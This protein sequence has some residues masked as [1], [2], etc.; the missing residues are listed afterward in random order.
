MKRDRYCDGNDIFC[1]FEIFSVTYGIY[2]VFPKN[3]KCDQIHDYLDQSSF[4]NIMFKHHTYGTYHRENEIL[5]KSKF[6][7]EIADFAIEK[8]CRSNQ[9]NIYD[10]YINTGVGSR[11]SP[12]E[13]KNVNIIS[14]I[15]KIG[16]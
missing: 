6:K 14:V 13:F 4:K 10:I 15:I 8:Y 7:G 5:T 3:E 9:K 11:K 2:N 12:K 16:Y 1:R